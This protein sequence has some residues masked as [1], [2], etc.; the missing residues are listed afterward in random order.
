MGFWKN[1]LPSRVFAPLNTLRRDYAGESHK[2]F[3]NE[4]EDLILNKILG[5][6]KSGFYVDVGAYHP[7]MYSNTYLFY[8]RGWSGINI[9]ANPL[10]I[11]KFNRFRKRD[12]NV[13][14]GVAETEGILTYYAFE[15]SAINTFSHELYQ[16]RL[17]ENKTKFLREVQVHTLTLANILDKY[18]P[19]NQIDF[20]DIDVEG[21]D[22]Q[23]LKSNNWNKYRP[24]A[25]LVEDQSTDKQSLTE[26]ETYKFLTQQ[27]YKLIAK[28]FNTL[29]F[30]NV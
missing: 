4:G 19:H 18:L 6:R 14:A 24:K 13:N 10:S 23:V 7:K 30:I 22:L 16:T 27:N 12:I 20:L 21:L 2:S 28:T 5:Q 1:I 3:S 17:Q 25:V 29:I 26:L 15:E 11:E 8:K 9:D